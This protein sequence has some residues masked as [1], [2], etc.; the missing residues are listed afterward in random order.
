MDT[1]AKISIWCFLDFTFCLLKCQPNL[2]CSLLKIFSCLPNFLWLSSFGKSYGWVLS[3]WLKLTSRI[4]SCG[5]VVSFAEV[6]FS[7]MPYEVMMRFS[8]YLKETFI[9]LWFSSLTPIFGI[10]ES[11]QGLILAWNRQKMTKLKYRS[12]FSC[13]W[14]S[15]TLEGTLLK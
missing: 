4:I 13:K 7:C 10:F 14:N 12:I 2:W 3:L 5:C 15:P 11:C 1:Y 9:C 6:N 8:F